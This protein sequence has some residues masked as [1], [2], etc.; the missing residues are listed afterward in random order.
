MYN[1]IGKRYEYEDDLIE[2]NLP[3]LVHKY[4]ASKRELTD[5]LIDYEYGSDENVKEKT[6]N[7]SINAF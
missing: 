6:N 2:N 7:Y 4:E 1:E 3:I 5:P